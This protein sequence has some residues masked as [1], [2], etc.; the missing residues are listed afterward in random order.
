MINVAVVNATK[1]SL[2]LQVK[3]IQ[4]VGLEEVTVS[5]ASTRTEHWFA[6]IDLDFSVVDPNKMNSALNNV[7]RM[8]KF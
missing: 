2:I 1:I 8:H 7:L 4:Q 3:T 6:N 5:L